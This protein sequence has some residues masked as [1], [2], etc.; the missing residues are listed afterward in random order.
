MNHKDLFKDITKKL[1]EDENVLALILYGSVSRN[2]ESTNSDID[3][4]VIVNENHCQKIHTIQCGITVES[5]EMNIDYLRDF[6]AKNEIPVLF[7]LVEGIVL[8]DKTSILD[9]FIAQAK[10]I[11][12]KGPPVNTK[13]DNERYATKKRSDIT[14]IYM[15]LLD[16]DDEIGFHYL[17]SLLITELIPLLNEN[18]HLW[19]KTRKK[20]IGY[21]KSQCYDGYKHIESLLCP[22]CSLH[23]KRNAAKGLINYALKQ[24][25]G[26]L[27][28]DAVIFKF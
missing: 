16:T 3:L 11:I 27:E 22:Q 1:Y 23:D 25:G 28:G 7:T 17:V 21:L 9:P 5:L 6:I 20:T 13:W 24:H 26:V 12:E 4:L 10:S 15:D 19:P 14:E 8:F 2:E 18:Y